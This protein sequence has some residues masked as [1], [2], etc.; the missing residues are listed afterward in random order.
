MNRDINLNLLKA[1]IEI[2]YFFIIF[3]YL[4]LLFWYSGTSG[5][6]FR[7]IKILQS[8]SFCKQTNIF[9]AAKYTEV[10]SGRCAA[11]DNQGWIMT[12][13]AVSETDRGSVVMSASTNMEECQNKCSA[14][15]G[16]RF[17]SQSSDGRGW[18]YLWRGETCNA[19]AYR[20]YKIYKKT[21][22]I[23]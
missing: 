1:I 5:I 17:I 13:N 6:K 11:W 19:H 4:L 21:R 20:E 18:C 22:G 9:L 2:I 7:L 16:C 10:G 3:K 12:D 23:I 15:E 8:K 14:T